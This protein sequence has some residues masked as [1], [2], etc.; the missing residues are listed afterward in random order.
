MNSEEKLK[1][2]QELMANIENERRAAFGN[3][4][5]MEKLAK[6][7]AVLFFADMRNFDGKPL[8][9]IKPKKLT[10]AIK[11]VSYG[12]YGRCLELYDKVSVGRLIV[13]IMGLNSSTKI[14]FPDE[15]GKPQKISAVFSETERAARLIYL[16]EQVEKRHKEAQSCT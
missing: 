4:F 3:A 10:K 11:K 16:L 5:Q 7:L 1:R 13:E 9:E 8:E 12:Q 2:G 6:E 14:E 15:H